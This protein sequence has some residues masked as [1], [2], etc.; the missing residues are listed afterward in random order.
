MTGNQEYNAIGSFLKQIVIVL[1]IRK[2]NG[3][4]RCAGLDP[5]LEISAIVDAHP[6]KFIGVKL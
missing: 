4:T 1:P 2:S 3:V 6:K 5:P